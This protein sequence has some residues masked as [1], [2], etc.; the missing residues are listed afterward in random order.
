MAKK[1][2]VNENSLKNLKQFTSEYQP[3][4]Q[5]KSEAQKKYWKEVRENEKSADILN[6]LLQ[7]AIPNK[8]LGEEITQKEN[9]LYGLLVKAI[10]ER[11]LKA[12]ELVLKIIGD[13][14]NKL[15]LDGLLNTNIQ[16]VYVT[17]EDKAKV[18]EHI[19][20]FING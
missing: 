10:E 5:R 15:T 19:E 11:D 20:K 9:M 7:K 12:I 14:D 1:R 16:K 3:S 18:D 2:E 13:L 8:A 17:K 4:P 6:R